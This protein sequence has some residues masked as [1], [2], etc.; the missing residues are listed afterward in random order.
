METMNWLQW[1]QLRER[2]KVN[3]EELGLISQQIRR[4]ALQ[5]IYKA[6]SGHPG[7]A[8]SC[9][10]VLA[11]LYFREL[12]VDPEKPDWEERDRFVLSKGHSC[13]A[14]YAALGLRGCFGADPVAVWQTFRKIGG[15]L[16][17]HPHVLATPWVETS[18]GSLGQG[19]SVAIGMAMGLRY[20]KSTARVCVM[21][22]DGEQQE[23]EVWEA[24]MSAAHYKLDNLCA[25][26]D[27]NKMQS[28][29][30]NEETM[31]IDCLRDRWHAFNWHV[32]EIDG[33]DFAAI[34][35]AFENG[36]S[37]TGK[38]TCIIAHTLK[39]K[40]VSYMEGSPAWHGS[41]KLKDDELLTAYR[42]LSIADDE[43]EAYRQWN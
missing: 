32:L 41:V 1:A 36:R 9:A 22:G 35:S 29:A 26:I 15:Q 23:G 10:D 33:H 14:L 28:D 7:G 43:L 37:T 42:D 12:S 39:G 16:Q 18:T 25:V 24:A 27:Y 4:L 21:M 5:M 2:G 34:E 17:G 38:P 11:F 13:P 8:L 19:V 40:G 30:L 31:G 6:Q 20:R 3:H